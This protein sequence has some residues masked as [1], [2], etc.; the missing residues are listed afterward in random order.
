VF[1]I[2]GPI[3]FVLVVL[4]ALSSITVYSYYSNRRDALALTDDILGAIERR[5]P[6]SGVLPKSWK[7]S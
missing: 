6:S 4:A 2:L 5:M 3:G 7:P 1:R